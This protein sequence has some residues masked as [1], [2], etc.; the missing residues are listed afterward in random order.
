MISFRRIVPTAP[1][2]HRRCPW[3][4][5]ILL[6]LTV[7]LLSPQLTE[8]INSLNLEWKDCQRF[9]FLSAPRRKRRDSISQGTLYWP[10]LNVITGIFLSSSS[11]DATKESD[12]LGRLLNHSRTDANC[13]TRLVSIKD[14]P[15]LILETIRDVKAGEELL[16]D[17][18]ERSK[19]V[20]QYH[21]WLK[22]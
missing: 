5:P 17:Y 19:D 16:Y 11:V 2:K 7:L 1:M 10:T 20:L 4:P 9:P 21:Q 12:R 8:D 6:L 3:F 14:K 22:S 13:A 15:Y 18:G